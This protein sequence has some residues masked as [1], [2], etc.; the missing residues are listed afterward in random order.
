MTAEVLD[1]LAEGLETAG[2][3]VV[4]QAVPI[5]VAVDELAYIIEVAVSEDFADPILY[6]PLK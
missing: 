3:I 2:L 1:R 4:P 5:R 6:L